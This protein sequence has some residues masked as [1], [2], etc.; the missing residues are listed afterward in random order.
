MDDYLICEFMSQMGKWKC[1]L[2][3]ESMLLLDVG[4]LVVNVCSIFTGADKKNIFEGNFLPFQIGL[5][6]AQITYILWVHIT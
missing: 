4:C 3:L 2:R 5:G 6:R 1:T